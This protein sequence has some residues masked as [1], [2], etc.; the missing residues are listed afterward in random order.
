MKKAIWGILITSLVAVLAAGI[1]SAIPGERKGPPE[2]IG[3]LPESKLTK[4]VFIRYAEGYAKPGTECGNGVCEPG[5]NARK[6]PADCKNGGEEPPQ[7]FCY[8]FLSGAKPKWNQPEDYRYDNQNLGNVSDWATG[9]W[10]DTTSAIIFG[11]GLSGAGTWGNYD[12][13]NSIVY[14]NYPQDGV[15]GVTAIWFRGKSI[16]EYDIM[17]DLDYFP[18]EKETDYDLE[19]VVLHEFGHAAGLG[20]LYD[21]VC[22]Q[23]VMYGY[24]AP[25]ETRTTLGSGDTAGIQILYGGI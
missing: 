21:T 5:E 2:F 19:T 13:K 1:A 7:D 3:D 10:D 16:Y 25:N 18:N 23:E 4:I 20:D 8:G 12:G 9:I 15:L 6:C 14:D 22:S 11:E 24:L 17:L